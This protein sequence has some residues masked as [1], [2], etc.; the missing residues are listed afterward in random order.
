[1]YVA[2]NLRGLSRSR[3][4]FVDH[5][6]DLLLPV[7]SYYCFCIRRI[8]RFDTHIINGLRLDFYI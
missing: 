2:V 1:M 3:V 5:L 7:D 6:N 8:S 4:E